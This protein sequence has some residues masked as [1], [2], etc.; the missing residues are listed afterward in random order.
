LERALRSDFVIIGNDWATGQN[1]PTSKHRIA[2]EL[3]RRGAKVLWIDGAG[4]RR[5]RIGSSQDRTRLLRRAPAVFRA[6][7]AAAEASYPSGGGVWVLV[8]PFI[9]LPH[10]RWVQLWNG[11]VCRWFSRFWTR[12]LGFIRPSLIVYIPVYA[13]AMRGWPGLR[14]YHCVDRWDAFS[15]YNSAVMAEMDA[16]CCRYADCIFATSSDLQERCLRH[17]HKVSLLLHGVDYGHF[18]KALEEAERPEDLPP[19]P[20]IGFIGLLSEWV[21][22]GMLVE[23][24]RENPDAHVVL[25]GKA[26]VE[27]GQ[28]SGAKNIHALGPRPFRDLPAYVA[29]FTVGI[30]PFRVNDLTRAV[31]PIKLREM[32]SAGCPVVSTALPEVVRFQGAAHGAVAIGQDRAEFLQHVRERLQSPLSGERRRAISESMQEETWEAKVTTLLNRLD[33]L[34]AS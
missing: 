10:L 24:A 20:L 4:M 1:N 25:I 19:G 17:S 21:D 13:E 28:L 34:C 3:A 6:P 30:I 11:F 18:R 12:I 7:K 31:N 5:P 33:T 27:I 26:D 23:L 8:P 2:H 16:R 14:I 29:H 9:P 22:L 15:T 32:L